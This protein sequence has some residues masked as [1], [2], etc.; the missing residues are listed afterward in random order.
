MTD[1]NSLIKKA[2]ESAEKRA[3]IQRE[4]DSLSGELESAKKCVNDELDR[5]QTAA[6]NFLLQFGSVLA[7]ICYIHSELLAISGSELLLRGRREKTDNLDF[8]SIEDEV[9]RACTRIENAAAALVLHRGSAEDSACKLCR[10]FNALKN[11]SNGMSEYK[12]K[13]FIELENETRKKENKLRVELSELEKAGTE[14]EGRLRKTLENTTSES[15]LDEYIQ[16]DSYGSPHIPLG[17]SR[18]AEGYNVAGV[19]DISGRVSSA[20]EWDLKETSALHIKASSIDYASGQFASLVKSVLIGCLYAYPSRAKRVLVCDKTGDERIMS[21]VGALLEGAP[22][23]FINGAGVVSS[24]NDIA[25][26]AQELKKTVERRLMLLGRT[27]LDDILTYNARNTDNVMPLIFVLAH[28]YPSGFSAGADEL[29]TVIKNGRKAGVYFVITENTDVKEGDR[30]ARPAPDPEKLGALK[31]SFSLRDGKP[32]LT[33]DEAIYDEVRSALDAGALIAALKEETEANEESVDFDATVGDEDFS[34]SPRRHEYSKTLVIPVGKDGARTL[35]LKLDSENDA[36]VIM[37][38][39]TGSGKSSLINALVLSAAKLYSPDELEINLISM[40]KSEFDVFKKCRLPH[41]KTLVTK[42]DIAGAVDVLNYLRDEM[43]RRMNTVGS[44]IVSY[45]ARV[46][47]EKRMPRSLVII[48]EYQ[49]LIVDNKARD[50]ISMIAQLGRSCGMSLILSSQTVPVDFR[51][52]LSLFRHR[53]EFK[54]SAVGDLI[55]EIASRRGELESAAGLCFYGRGEKVTLARIA[56]PGKASDER[57]ENRIENIKAKYVGSEMSLRSRVDMPLVNDEEDIP[58]ISAAAKREFVEDGI[59]RIKLGK[60]Y[61]SL[62]TLEYS[63]ESG[64][65]VLCL[66]GDY[67]LTKEL[68]VEIVKDVLNLSN[69]AKH[70]SLFYIDL[71]R[72]PNWARKPSAVKQWRDTWLLSSQ[73]RFAYY[74]AGQ[75]FDA[76]K[77]IEKLIDERERNADNLDYDISPAVAVITC[78]ELISYDSDEEDMLLRLMER[79]R[80]FNVFFVLQ[81]NRFS[82]SINGITREMGQ[83]KNGVLV[84]DRYVEGEP[85]SSAKLIEFLSQ[86]LAADTTARDMLTTFV[87]APLNRGLNILCSGY[88]VTCFIPYRYSEKYFK[89]NK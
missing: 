29:E 88:D 3:R 49:R 10:A 19:G 75:F 65:N 89:A 39:T 85:Y 13:R 4:I 32:A 48:D 27:G 16:A 57:F 59:C 11:L 82:R 43:Q 28:G 47:K 84:P 6:N 7:N 1:I 60:K 55:S 83:I 33:V 76:L 38:G 73:G 69:G 37:C 20:L 18:V 5:A 30:F 77:S 50:T 54:G 79:G 26:A 40:V 25:D 71:N 46:A 58:Y 74:G 51:S 12:N 44:D 64:N 23:L 36:H 70:T 15:S 31:I 86:T 80:D 21:F 45:N 78:T 14:I 61:L 66:L 9:K 81:F 22:S 8:S 24:E 2:E 62:S 72:N 41:L 53:F 63:L 67:L 42:D 34:S 52:A 87:T 56:Y 68:E 35:E 17:I